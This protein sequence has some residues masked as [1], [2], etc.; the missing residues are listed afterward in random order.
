VGTLKFLCEIFSITPYLSLAVGF[1]IG[2]LFPRLSCCSPSLTLPLPPA[3]QPAAARTTADPLRT[4]DELLL[5]LLM[6]SAPAD[7]AAALKA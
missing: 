4:T 6:A 2:F 7:P 1:P 3:L 5:L